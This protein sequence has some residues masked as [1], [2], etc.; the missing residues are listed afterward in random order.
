MLKINTTEKAHK[1]TINNPQDVGYEGNMGNYKSP[2]NTQFHSYVSQN[3]LIANLSQVFNFWT[4]FNSF[5]CIDYYWF[6]QIH[7]TF[8]FSLSFKFFAML[9]LLNLQNSLKFKSY[10]LLPNDK[11]SS[12]YSW[13]QKDQPL[14]AIRSEAILWS[15][16]SYSLMLDLT[17]STVNL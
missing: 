2:I 8:L 15:W 5:L 3:L 7:S 11:M 12:Y 4:I 6:E 17:F 9:N 13:G 14:D 10:K 16:I 1:G